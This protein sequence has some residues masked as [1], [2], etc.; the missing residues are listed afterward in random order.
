M[1]DITKK[2]VTRNGYK[3]VGLKYVPYNSCGEK[4]T[5]PIKGSIMIPRRQPIYQIW[6]E[7]GANQ[8][9]AESEWD[10]IEVAE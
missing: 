5:F 7:S 9:F 3:V 8:L 1:I 6:M 2:H 10:L 4:V